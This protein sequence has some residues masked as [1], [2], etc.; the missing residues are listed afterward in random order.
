M[1]LGGRGR[2]GNTRLGECPGK[3]DY[4]AKGV[5][6]VNPINLVAGNIV[7]SVMVGPATFKR[8]TDYALR[9]GDIIIAR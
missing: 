2:S 4:V 1:N 9:A 8:L 5:P 7:P 3:S 6:V